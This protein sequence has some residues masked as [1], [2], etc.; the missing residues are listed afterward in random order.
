MGAIGR[1]SESIR[2]ASFFFLLGLVSTLRAKKH[3]PSPV[4]FGA[5]D[6]S[7]MSCMVAGRMVNS[8]VSKRLFS[9]ASYARR[10]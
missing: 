5:H 2:F 6:Y 9:D 1:K 8:R 4:L 10:L 3:R 7:S